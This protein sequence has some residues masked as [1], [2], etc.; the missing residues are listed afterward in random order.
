MQEEAPTANTKIIHRICIE[1]IFVIRFFAAVVAVVVV[2][3]FS[4]SWERL[5]SSLLHMHHPHPWYRHRWDPFILLLSISATHSP[6][7]FGK[8]ALILR[9]VLNGCLRSRPACSSGCFNK[10]NYGRTEQ[11][12]IFTRLMRVFFL[13]VRLHYNLLPYDIVVGSRL[14]IRP[15]AVHCFWNWVRAAIHIMFACVRGRS[16]G[17]PR[18][19]HPRISLAPP[20]EWNETKRLGVRNL[21]CGHHR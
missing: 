18:R 19:C 15:V 1:Y 11:F 8:A 20:H 17:C 6:P 5:D 3:L 12:I 10:K 9:S 14:A 13:C 4:F 21:L 16:P 7:F 2:A